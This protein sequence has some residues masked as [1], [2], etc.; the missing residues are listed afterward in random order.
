LGSQERPA[1]GLAELFIHFQVPV[2]SVIA[3]V[4]SLSSQNLARFLARFVSGQVS[5]TA[6]LETYCQTNYRL[7]LDSHAISSD[8]LHIKF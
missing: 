8:S 6:L 4:Q 7:L 5:M 2:S 3:F 1:A